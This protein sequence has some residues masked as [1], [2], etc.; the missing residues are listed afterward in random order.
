MALEGNLTIGLAFLGGAMAMADLMAKAV[1]SPQTHYLNAKGGR[2]ESSGMW[3]KVGLAEGALFVAIA[4]IIDPR[5]RKAFL[6]G[7][8][9]EGLIT[10]YEY[11]YATKAGLANA[12]AP[13]EDW[14]NDNGVLVYSQA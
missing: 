7:G 2:A 11:G 4:A 3:V 5:N 1:S 13:T 14:G 10:W 9:L 6:A 12:E 8:I